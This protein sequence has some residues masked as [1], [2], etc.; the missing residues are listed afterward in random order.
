MAAKKLTRKEIVQQDV[1]RKTLTDTSHWAVSNFKLL[2]GGLVAVLA[3]TAGILLW[4]EY[5]GSR[6]EQL[7]SRFADALDLFHAPVGA[8]A[9]ASQDNTIKPKYTF[10]DDKTKYEKSLS[11][12][13]DLADQYSGT[14]IGSLARYYAALSM[15]ELGQADQ[16]RKA[17]QSVVADSRFIEV[18]DLARNTLADLDLADEKYD[19]AI[20]LLRQILDQPSEDF[21]KEIVL[22]KLGQILE[23]QGDLAAAL[24]EYRKVTTEYPGTNTASEASTRIRRLEPRVGQSGAEEAAAA[25]A[26]TPAQE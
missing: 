22:L 26:E 12:F 8:D 6:Q 5:S 9:D 15:N 7:Q 2:V 20:A 13:Q 19:D 24:E 4:Q 11:A 16:A 10:K 23:K 18:K 3:I 25:P 1:I 14:K 21:P 17:L